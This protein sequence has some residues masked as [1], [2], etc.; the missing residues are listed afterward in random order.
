[1]WNRH[2][3][4]FFFNLCPKQGQLLTGYKFEPVYPNF[5]RMKFACTVS[6][7]SHWLSEFDL[8]QLPINGSK[9]EPCREPLGPGSPYGIYCFWGIYRLPAG[10]NNNFPG[11]LVCCIFL[12]LYLLRFQNWQFFS[13]LFHS[14]IDLPTS[15]AQIFSRARSASGRFFMFSAAEGLRQKRAV[16]NYRNRK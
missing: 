10:K 1:M 15:R 6:I 16:D 5:I 4:V 2:W 12:N 8:L 14:T 3:S 11:K 13:L 9:Q 7:Q